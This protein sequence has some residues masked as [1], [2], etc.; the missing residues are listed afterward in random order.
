MVD[1]SAAGSSCSKLTSRA[2]GAASGSI[3]APD[4][5][6]VQLVRANAASQRSGMTSPVLDWA[7][8]AASSRNRQN[9]LISGA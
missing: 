8:C 5:C 7:T 4:S 1:T 9:S 6:G 3:A 2:A